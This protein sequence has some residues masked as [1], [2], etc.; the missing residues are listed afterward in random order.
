MEQRE[1]A[2]ERI[3]RLADYYFEIFK[4]L[5]SKKLSER[6]NLLR[7][8]SLFVDLC[9]V[10]QGTNPLFSIKNE[11]LKIKIPENIIQHFS[12]EFSTKTE[13]F[14]QETENDIENDLNQYKSLFKLIEKSRQSTETGKKKLYLCYPF[15]IFKRNENLYYTPIWFIEINAYHELRDNSIKIEP[16]EET[17][18]NLYSLSKFIDDL[19]EKKEVISKAEEI[20]LFN[21]ED[22]TLIKEII[23][24]I[25][26]I[27]P[28][29]KREDIQNKNLGELQRVYKK[30]DLDN[31]KEDTLY[32]V[33]NL[34]LWLL[35]KPDYHLEKALKELKDLKP[36]ETYTYNQGSLIFD[37][38][39]SDEEHT[40]PQDDDNEDKKRLISNDLIL[41]ANEEQREV[42]KSALKYKVVPVEGPPGTGKSHT[43]TN[44]ALYLIKEGYSV[45]ITSYKEKALEVIVNFLEKLKIHDYLYISWLKGERKSKEI[46]LSKL[47]NIKYQICKEDKSSVL[48]IK[49]KNLEK[50]R[51]LIEEKFKEYYE[52]QKIFGFFQ[53]FL[54]ENL[55]FN[56]RVDLSEI[57]STFKNYFLRDLKDD[58]SK[59]ITERIKNIDPYEN[60][61]DQFEGL[62]TD[63]KLNLKLRQFS[64]EDFIKIINIF[65]Y[66]KQFNF[67]EEE[68]LEK[69]FEC[70]SKILSN[71]FVDI[72]KREIFQNN[73]NTTLEKL[74][75][76]E[77]YSNEL[78]DREMFDSLL[79]YIFELKNSKKNEE[80]SLLYDMV[81]ELQSVFSRLISYEEISDF[82]NFM[83]SILKNIDV[84]YFTIEKIKEIENSI[85]ELQNSLEKFKKILRPPNKLKAIYYTIIEVFSKILDKEHSLLEKQIRDLLN[86]NKNL[87]RILEIDISSLLNNERYRKIT[88]S[89]INEYL[90][91]FNYLKE[92][93]FF[94]L[95]SQIA[96]IFEKYEN[97]IYKKNLT[98]SYY[99]AITFINEE[100]NKSLISNY[101]LYET[102]KT[103]TLI[104]VIIDFLLN[105]ENNPVI[106]ILLETYKDREDFID[107]NL[108]YSYY[109]ITKID[110]F[111]TKLNALKTILIND[112]KLEKIILL[113][114]LSLE[115]YKNFY[116]LSTFLYENNIT[117]PD[118]IFICIILKEVLEKIEVFDDIDSLKERLDEIKKDININS[119]EILSNL[120]SNRI[121]KFNNNA[122][123]MGLVESLKKILK[124]KKIKKIEEIK[125]K[126][127]YIKILDLFKL[128]VVKIEDVFKLFPFKPALFDYVIIDEASQLLPI[129]L[130]PLLFITKRIIIIGD[131]KQLKSPELLFFDEEMS[132]SKFQAENLSNDELVDVF[133]ITRDSSCLKLAN[134]LPDKLLPPN[135][136][137][138]KEHFR[139]LPEI[140]KFSN[141]K[142][143]GG[144]L[145]IMTEGL[146]RIGNTFEF[147]KVENAE[148]INKVN[149]KEAEEVIKYLKKCLKDPH[150][151][152]YSFGVLSFFREQ[153]DYILDR[154]I[155]EKE[156]DI[157]LHRIC[158]EKED[159]NEPVLISTADGFQGD[160]RDVIIYSL[161][162]APNSSPKIIS[163]LLSSSE[164][165]KNRLNVALTRAR[166]KMVFFISRDIK[167]FPANLL[168]DFLFYAKGFNI[169]DIISE[170][171]DSDF[172]RDVYE[173]LTKKGY[174]LYP[175]YEAC[176]YRIDL[177]LFI[178]NLRIG[179]ECDGWQH[180]DKY[181]E[182]NI[183]DIE[184]QEI[185]ER[186]GW[187]ILR[188]PSTRYWKDPD[189]YIE[190]LIEKINNIVENQ[191]K[192]EQTKREVDKD[193]KH[194]EEITSY[195]EKKEVSKE[196]VS[197]AKNTTTKSVSVEISL[198]ETSENLPNLFESKSY[199]IW[200]KLAKWAKENHRLSP[201]DRSFA[202]NIAE[203]IKRNY[204]LSDK[205]LR[206][207][208]RIF[209]IAIKYGFNPN[210]EEKNL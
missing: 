5:S 163:S 62:I 19:P 202:Y 18:F 127:E 174:R 184:R 197:S 63:L 55:F 135:R 3:N 60:I 77:E 8:G 112:V 172:E 100:I 54:Y 162:Y 58:G 39:S 158:K 165:G 31:L 117:N 67:F 75:L 53:E 123:N 14:L 111:R 150:Y 151:K 121:N 101:K 138:L 167:E 93:N 44:L 206:Y 90:G 144:M 21:I 109:F 130:L 51:I 208:L 107:Q 118:K 16:I 47:E 59:F 87:L 153:A 10:L 98:V 72:E 78:K 169:S 103:L 7:K 25:F 120:I 79:K 176:G 160:E 122:E 201:K 2:L 154:F 125:N 187:I 136:I 80:L 27:N 38:F 137:M 24:T 91:K 46:I 68:I 207:A 188:I 179:I 210:E 65:T 69:D 13:S 152:K 191:K 105:K 171:F 205:Q 26:N 41:P 192:E 141:E 28:F 145:R 175:Q 143:Y 199:K 178:E 132:N 83:N 81:C 20:N 73:I 133:K 180:Y 204:Q 49:K 94:N 115:E 56:D 50:E 71:I 131:D 97:E 116:K 23:Y 33:N 43:I 124:T 17:E 177:A 89:R 84:H 36:D 82:L 200:K 146:E 119:K 34:V 190:R 140:I 170:K 96:N 104:G 15:I 126:S 185:L 30:S 147:Y 40:E 95:I 182:L 37:V 48:F 114:D 149:R 9:D 113:K 92:I 209:K 12:T 22:E 85:N 186:A 70:L 195:L 156:K 203:L 110:S 4:S 32:L 155:E 99:E 173:R 134:L 128:W 86:K 1:K 11:S 198:E 42:I 74:E 161:R 29:L 57:E 61:E 183:D 157:E 35:S 194:E 108:K 164:F 64:Y 196:N 45:L 6:N 193:K 168:K 66:F 129:Y 189:D 159:N 102:Y 106:K 139:C 52:N 88:I 181:G 142:F 166:R 148:D 76:I